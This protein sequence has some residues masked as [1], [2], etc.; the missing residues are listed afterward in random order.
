M[1]LITYKKYA[2]NILLGALMRS[3]YSRV[4]L[5]DLHHLP[6]KVFLPQKSPDLDEREI[7]FE[8]ILAHILQSALEDET[9]VMGLTPSLSELE[10]RPQH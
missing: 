7:G 9:L 4:D 5:E 2:I 3:D 6:F 8:Q 10:D 1:S